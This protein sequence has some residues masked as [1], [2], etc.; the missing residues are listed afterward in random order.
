MIKVKYL[1]FVDDNVRAYLTSL[2]HCIFY[3]YYILLIL[4][5]LYF[6][7]ISCLSRLFLE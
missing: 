5:Y 1:S 7:F 2:L 6:L 3:L 4:F